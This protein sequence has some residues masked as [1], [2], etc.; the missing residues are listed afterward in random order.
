M[1]KH[2]ET[3][4]ARFVVSAIAAWLISATVLVLLASVAVSLLNAEAEAIGYISSALSFLTAVFAGA[5]AMHI[6]KRGAIFTGLVAGV[7]ITTLALTLGFIISGNDIE[8][9]G[10][11][12]VVTFTLAGGLT[13]SVF[14]PGTGKKGKSTASGRRR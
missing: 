3:P 1:N 4:D 7:T 5:R 10:V 13:G 8:L 11:L 14:F 2:I 9:D 6:R 12:S